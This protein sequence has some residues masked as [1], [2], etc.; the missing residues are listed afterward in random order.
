V[1]GV[2]PLLLQKGYDVLGIIGE[3]VFAC[4][5]LFCIT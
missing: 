5:N 3:V 1:A 2:P 4:K